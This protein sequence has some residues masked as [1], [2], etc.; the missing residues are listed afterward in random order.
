M[1]TPQTAHAQVEATA[2]AQVEAAAEPQVEAAVDDGDGF[3]GGPRDTSILISYADHVAYQLWT[4]EVCLLIKKFVNFS[5]V[6]K[7]V[8]YVCFLMVFLLIGSG[9]VEGSLPWEEAAVV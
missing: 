6:D 1:G 9:G 3:P 4:G 8:I 5:L 2:K 7:F